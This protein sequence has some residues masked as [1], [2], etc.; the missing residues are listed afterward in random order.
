MSY[1]NANQKKLVFAEQYGN[2][3]RTYSPIEFVLRT[4]NANKGIK[5]ATP[6]GAD[7]SL[8]DGTFLF[9]PG[10]K[11]TIQMNYYPIQCDAEGSC[12]AGLC[13]NPDEVL[14]PAQVDFNITQCTATKKI[15]IN[16][17]DVRQIDFNQWDFTGTALEA[18]G[19]LMPAARKL[20]AEDLTAYLYAK[21]GTHT[22]GNAV[23]RISP[24]IS[25]SGAVNPLG[26]RISIDKAYMD[27][28]MES[29]YMMGGSEVYYWKNMVSI[30]GLNASGQNINRIDTNNVWYDDNILT[31]VAGDPTNGGWIIA[32][33]PQIFK[34]VTYNENAGLFRTDLAVITDMDRLYKSGGGSD[35][36]LGTLYDEKIGLFWDLYVNFEKCATWNGNKPGWTAQLKLQ[37][38]MFVMPPVSCNVASFNGITK[39]RT[40]P[41]VIAA[42]PTGDTPSPA[43]ASTVRSWTPSDVTLNIYESLIGG[44]E[45][46]QNGD[47]VVTT[48]IAELVSYMN[49]ATGN[50]YQFYVSGST[51]RYTGVSNISVNINNGEVTGTF[52]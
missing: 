20:L 5:I 45:V 33:D 22:D 3:G 34:F 36:I 21:A 26:G 31:T 24:S 2:R 40:C 17:E 13:D 51:V 42:C 25:T 38:D 47:P 43:I 18:I 1:A 46:T 44:I 35:F 8:G 37:W 28:G 19:S 10:K 11:R 50:A 4:S 30:G 27:A 14:E 41:E 6:Q 23:S 15:G 16:A 48:T 39:W 49:D 12:D 7:V 29:P 9:A 32:I 52:S